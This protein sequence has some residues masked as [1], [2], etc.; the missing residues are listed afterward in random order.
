M[1][2]YENSPARSSIQTYRP[3]RVSVDFSAIRALPCRW[4][5]ADVEELV[6]Y[7]AKVFEIEPLNERSIR[8]TISRTRLREGSGTRDGESVLFNNTILDHITSPRGELTIGTIT[9][10]MRIG[11]IGTA[12]RAISGSDLYQPP[13][14]FTALSVACFDD[15]SGLERCESDDGSVLTFRDRGSGATV[16]F[17][18]WKDTGFYWE[19][20]TEIVT[21]GLDFD[22]AIINSH[23]LITAWGQTCAVGVIDEDS[24][25][26]DDYLDE[27]EWGL[28]SEQPER[29][30]SLCRVQ[31]NGHRLAGMVSTGDK[32]FTINDVPFPTGWP[33]DWPPPIPVPDPPPGTIVANPGVLTFVSKSGQAVTKEITIT[34]THS[35]T[36]SVTVENATTLDPPP[37]EPGPLPEPPPFG[38][39]PSGEFSN[40]SG[41]FDIPAN[42][43]IKIPVTY[44]GKSDAGTVHGNLRIDLDSKIVDIALVGENVMVFAPV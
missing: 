41:S 12:R 25:T 35:E 44:K 13:N 8:G 39:V 33:N 31:W 14:Y 27:Y 11:R 29:V 5:F 26:N 43:S 19:M 10:D 34:S 38:G 17:E 37:D 9:H 23:Y 20:G 21:N 3:P 32:C 28:F 22:A 15:A 6:A 2:K 18:S 1:T 7:V 16:R 4:K 24:D 30:V 36:K 42:G 40:V